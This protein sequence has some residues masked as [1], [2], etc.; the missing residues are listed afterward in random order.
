MRKII[1]P[2]YAVES[3]VKNKRWSVFLKILIKVVYVA[4]VKTAVTAKEKRV[5]PDKF[6][7]AILAGDPPF[8]IR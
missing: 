1:C 5:V 8:F 3:V 7:A 2:Y 6:I 4:A